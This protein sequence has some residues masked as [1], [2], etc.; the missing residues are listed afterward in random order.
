MKKNNKAFSSFV[1]RILFM[2]CLPCT[3]FSCNDSHKEVN[4]F[5]SEYDGKNKVNKIS[6]RGKV[7]KGYANKEVQTDPLT[8]SEDSLEKL[9]PY[10]EQIRKENKELK[11]NNNVLQN[12][13]RYEKDKISCL[14]SKIAELIIKLTLAEN[15][16]KQI[17]EQQTAKLNKLNDDLKKS[18][19]IIEKQKGQIRRLFKT[20]GQKDI[21]IENLKKNK[22]PVNTKQICGKKQEESDLLK[23]ISQK[24]VTLKNLRIKIKNQKDKIDKLI[25]EKQACEEENKNLKTSIE[26]LQKELEVDKGII[27]KR[28]SDLERL[29]SKN[30]N[31]IIKTEKLIEEKQILNNEN[32]RLKTDLEKI[33]NE[34]ET[35]EKNNKYVT[36]DYLAKINS[37]SNDILDKDNTIYN[38]RYFIY[39]K[40]V[41]IQLLSSALESLSDGTL[42]Q[43]FLSEHDLTKNENTFLKNRV[44]NQREE[45]RRLV[46]NNNNLKEK[47]QILKTNLEKLQDD[48]TTKD[49]LIQK[50]NS[51]LKKTKN[52]LKYKTNELRFS[53]IK[54]DTKINFK[55]KE[56]ES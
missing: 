6:T 7:K 4:N 29:R 56:G 50:K 11:E 15:P 1:L 25:I 13:V 17:I 51:D 8:D 19:E 10:Y 54:N 16:N 45:L 28:N 30:N 37:L 48:L 24:D 35:Y 52:E 55:G 18:R 14:N 27:Q 40:N 32:K 12:E 33:K 2:S 26:E 20:I 5:N 39:E 43:D 38:L 34:N 47:N 46:I 53:H 3:L 49:D 36:T 23:K 21:V 31:Q 42:S 9:E 41:E 44:E 22:Q